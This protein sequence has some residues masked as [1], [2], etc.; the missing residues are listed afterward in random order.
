MN[1]EEQERK[2]LVRQMLYANTEEEVRLA[3]KAASEWLL[4]HPNDPMVLSAGEGLAMIEGA[5]AEIKKVTT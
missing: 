3:H 4:T 5:L 2:A 1:T